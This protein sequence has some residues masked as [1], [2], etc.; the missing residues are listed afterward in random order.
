MARTKPPLKGSFREWLIDCIMSTDFVTCTMDDHDVDAYA[1]EMGVE[2]DVLLEAR[3]RVLRELTERA[4]PKPGGTKRAGTAHYQL[5]LLFPEVVYQAWKY[6]CER[7]GLLGSALLRSM[8]HAYLSGS[9]EPRE[10]SKHWVWRGIGYEVTTKSWKRQHKSRYPYRER[11]LITHGAK[12]ALFRRSVRRA[13]KPSTIV[14]ALI[15]YCVDGHW[16][17]PG[18]IDIIDQT[19]MF[20]DEQRYFMG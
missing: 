9:W 5:E 11:A 10:I 17:Q 8:V 2:P 18:T 3:L 7:R 20:D 6:E 1:H 13:C 16:A 12:R 15:I 19:S 14:R 4:A